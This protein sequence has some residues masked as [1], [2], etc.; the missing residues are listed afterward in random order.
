MRVKP[1]WYADY[2]ERPLGAKTTAVAPP[3]AGRNSVNP[4]PPALA[5][6]EPHEADDTRLAA[7]AGMA[8]QAI[9][10][11][12]AANADLEATV[13]WAVREVFGEMD[14]AS[15]LGRPPHTESTADER[16]TRLLTDPVELARIAGVVRSILGTGVDRIGDG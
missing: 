10:A 11:R 14:T 6:V 3:I 2:V 7:L 12:L 8:L 16:I 15:E 5:L 1:Q 9:E 4:E 13:A